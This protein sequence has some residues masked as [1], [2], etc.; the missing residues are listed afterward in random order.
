MNISQIKTKGILFILK[1]RLR[2]LYSKPQSLQDSAKSRHDAL[3]HESPGHIS[4]QNFLP[5]IKFAE[6]GCIFIQQLGVKQIW[7]SSR[8]NVKGINRPF[9]NFSHDSPPNVEKMVLFS[10]CHNVTCGHGL[11]DLNLFQNIKLI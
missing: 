7:P 6:V 5:R 3:C 4:S 9:V 8:S 11:H 10:F 2:I 1:M